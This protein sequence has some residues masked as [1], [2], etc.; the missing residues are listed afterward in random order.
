MESSTLCA[1]LSGGTY[2]EVFETGIYCLRACYAR[3]KYKREPDLDRKFVQDVSR[4]LQV[5]IET[6]LIV[7]GEVN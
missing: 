7:V 2:N 3:R 1:L 5:F 4:A 6:G